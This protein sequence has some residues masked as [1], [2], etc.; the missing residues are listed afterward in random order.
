M[1][2]IIIDKFPE[3]KIKEILNKIDENTLTN[4]QNKVVKEFTIYPK[5]NFENAE[6]IAEIIGVSIDE[7]ME[8]REI[9]TNTLNYR[10]RLNDKSLHKISK[11]IDLMNKVDNQY[12]ISGE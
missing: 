2:T 6:I 4:K 8:T 11:I 5:I 7:L 1:S 10:N 3:R 9:S 12:L